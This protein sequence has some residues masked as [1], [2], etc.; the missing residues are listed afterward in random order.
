MK[1]LDE[2]QDELYRELY[3]LTMTVQPVDGTPETQELLMKQVGILNGRIDVY[4]RCY[5]EEKLLR[6][7]AVAFLRKHEKR[8]FWKVNEIAPTS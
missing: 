4:K 3:D 5:A 1:E 8:A 2:Q 7:R 6:M